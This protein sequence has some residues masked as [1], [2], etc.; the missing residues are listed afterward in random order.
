MKFCK[1]PVQ[2]DLDLARTGANGATWAMSRAISEAWYRNGYRHNHPDSFPLATCDLEKWGIT[3]MQKSRALSF[4]TKLG[5]IQ[6]DRRSP[7]NPLV[8]MTRPEAFLNLLK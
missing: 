1:V 4:L 5:W 6:M 2:L 8:I 7:K 3:K